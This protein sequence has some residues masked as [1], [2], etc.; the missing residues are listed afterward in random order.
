MDLPEVDDLQFFDRVARCAT[1]TEAARTWGVSTSAVSKRLARLENRIGIR[2]INRSTRRLSLTGEGLHYA[3]GVA[4]IL[5]RIADLEES[6]TTDQ[7][8]LRG[9]VA[10]HSTIGLGR[11]HI[12]PLLG[13]LRTRHP[14]VEV[15]LDLSHLPLNITG[16]SFDLAI[17]VGR[18]KDS[19]LQ[20]R[21]LHENRRV[22][23]AA[24]G[25]LAGRTRPTS[26]ADLA[27]HQCIVIRE[28]DSDYAIWRFGDEADETAI[29]VHGSM[30]SNDGDI[31]TRWCLQGHGLLMRSLWQV[32][33]MFR[34][35]TLEQVLPE[36]PTPPADIYAV[37]G[38]GRPPRR[39]L[40]VLDHL[41]A[42]LRDRIR[43]AASGGS[44]GEVR[45]G[46]LGEYGD[47]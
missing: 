15:E 17:R 37:H 33:P 35:G 10:V 24:P 38:A 36:I 44:P 34:D 46:A 14:G 43:P 7:R 31:A 5:G 40:A 16:T 28:N 42:G 6:V 23:C 18:L 41:Q 19:R 25:Y 20:F 1:L 2:L 26:P 9:R 13:T 11:A 32:A 27:D 4:E 21:R 29:R 3:A 30:I 39:V 8:A 22:L 12:A 45:D 47:G